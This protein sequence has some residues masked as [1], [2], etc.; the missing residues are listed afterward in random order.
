MHAGP[1]APKPPP[2]GGTASPSQHQAQLGATRLCIPCSCPF[3]RGTVTAP[4]AGSQGMGPRGN[5]TAL[6]LQ[7][8][9]HLP[10]T[11]GTGKPREM[12]LVKPPQTGSRYLEAQE[13]RHALPFPAADGQ[14][15]VS[16][17]YSHG[18]TCSEPSQV[19]RRFPHASARSPS[20]GLQEQ[21]KLTPLWGSGAP[22]LTYP[23]LT[24]P[25]GRC[26]ST[27]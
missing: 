2:H 11:R 26:S 21:P 13:H 7:A 15:A 19:P 9:C 27:G 23:P 16:P 25:S 24:G 10:G 8:L 3:S 6:R 17:R 14:R 5:A 4:G 1:G 12:P 22:H 20:Q 18:S